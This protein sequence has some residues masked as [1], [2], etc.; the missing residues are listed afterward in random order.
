M[1][2]NQAGQL[3][4]GHRLQ[5]LNGWRSCVP[6]A[7]ETLRHRSV[8]DVAAGQNH[9]ARVLSN[10][11]VHVWGCGDDGRL[12]VGTRDC[13]MQP[14]VVSSLKAAGVKARSV[15]CGARHTAI[16][17]DRDLLYVWGANEFG[18]LGCGDNVPRLKPC[19]RSTPRRVLLNEDGGDDGKRDRNGECV[20]K[21]SC[22]WAHTNSVTHARPDSVM[23]N[24]GGTSSESSG[25]S[26]H[27]HRNLE[28]KQ[29]V[30]R[31]E[32][33]AR[34]CTHTTP[35]GLPT[36]LQHDN[37]RR[38]GMWKRGR[39]RTPAPTT[40][41][42]VTLPGASN[43]KSPLKPPAKDDRRKAMVSAFVTQ[44]A[45]CAGDAKETTTERAAITTNTPAVIDDR[46]AA[47]RGRGQCHTQRSHA[48]FAAVAIKFIFF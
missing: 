23:E 41:A 37:Q 30:L 31:R 34:W 44:C 20:R 3:G 8:L 17:S 46:I 11:E 28:S 6:I 26:S 47:T 43:A 19:L 13:E 42:L 40:K 25:H 45:D 22:G 27:F 18:Q 2:Y 10:G 9:S 48:Q 24:G 32:E 36:Y 12:G 15:R 4:I 29:F 1:G 35:W 39:H 7:V 16:V 21:V 33:A 38:G 5:H 14:V